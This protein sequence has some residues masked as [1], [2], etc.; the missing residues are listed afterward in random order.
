M[1]EQ[2]VFVVFYKRHYSQKVFSYRTQTCNKMPC[3]ITVGI[4]LVV[5]EDGVYPP[6][7]AVNIARWM[8]H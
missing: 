3:R 7:G 6:E 1:K 4:L 5:A 8:S 2:P